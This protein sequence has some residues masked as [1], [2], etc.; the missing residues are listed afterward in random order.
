MW[1]TCGGEG[2]AGTSRI[3]TM[4]A[5]WRVRGTGPVFGLRA[6]VW[7]SPFYE[8]NFWDHPFHFFESLGNST[9][10]TNKGSGNTKLVPF[11]EISLTKSNPWEQNPW[12]RVRDRQDELFAITTSRPA[13]HL[14]YYDWE[15][16]REWTIS[17]II[18]NKMYAVLARTVIKRANFSKILFCLISP[19]TNFLL[20][21]NFL[22]R[23][24]QPL[25]TESFFIFPS[26][27]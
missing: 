17:E 23:Q 18:V 3:G 21:P 11:F 4:R 13:M 10:Q 6:R 2:G 7:C 1:G 14:G 5:S 8:S 20:G 25:A 24:V 15:L 27:Q 19:T 22:P 16:S 26:R 12:E 9:Q